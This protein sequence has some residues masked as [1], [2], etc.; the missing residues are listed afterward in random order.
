[1]TLGKERTKK[2][3]GEY[4]NRLTS[5]ASTRNRMIL[6]HNFVN[7]EGLNHPPKLVI[8]H[9]LGP[10]DEKYYLLY[11]NSYLLIRYP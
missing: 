7:H 2:M 11:K 3:K 5:Q 4:C 1:M 6:V 9:E 10:N 8:K